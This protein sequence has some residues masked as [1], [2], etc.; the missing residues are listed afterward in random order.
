MNFWDIIGVNVGVLLLVSIERLL[1]VLVENGWH[2][3]DL[4]TCAGSGL[5]S[6]L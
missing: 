4:G 1:A 6:T 5:P 2:H 3:V